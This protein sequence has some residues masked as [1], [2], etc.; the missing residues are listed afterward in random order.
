M[1]WS[2]LGHFLVRSFKAGFASGKLTQTQRQG[3]IVLVPKSGKPKEK[4][5][6]WRPISLLNTTQKI[7]S[8]AMANRLRKVMNKLISPSQKGFMKGRFIGECIRT[9][10]DLLWDAKHSAVSKRGLI[11]FADYRRA[12]DSLSHDFMYE[13]L[14]LFNFGPNFIRWIRVMLN[15]AIS[16][17]SQNK[18]TSEFFPIQRGCRQGDCCSPL[19]F[20]LCAEVLSIA[21]RNDVKVVGY[22]INQLEVKI[23][24]FA[25]DCTF[26]LDGTKESLDNCLRVVNF[27]SEAS[28][29]VL[30]TDKTQ[31][32]WVGETPA[33]AYV[34]YADFGVIQGNFK[35]LGII[36]TKDLID[37]NVVNFD[38]KAIDIRNLLKGWLRRKLTVYGKRVVLKT[39]ALA[40]LTNILM[41]LPCPPEEKISNLQKSFFQFLWNNGPDKIK[42]SHM[43]LDFGIPCLRTYNDSLKLSWI[44]RYVCSENAW[45]DLIEDQ[46]PKAALFFTCGDKSLSRSI[47][48]RINPF[49]EEVF[50]TWDSF[51]KCFEVDSENVRLQ[52]LFLS[53]Y[54]KRNREVLWNK[55]LYEA[56][57]TSVG[58]L[59]TLQGNVMTVEE[60][61]RAYGIQIQLLEH[62]GMVRSIRSTC[63]G[64][65]PLRVVGPILQPALSVVLGN[66]SGCGLFYK[67]LL[68]LRRGES[69]SV[70]RS[71]I[72]WNANLQIETDWKV[73]YKRHLSCTKNT[74]LL[75]FQDRILHRILT[76]NVFVSKFT[77]TSPMCTFCYRERETLLHLFV[78]CEKVQSIWRCIK[79][80]IRDRTRC[81]VEL[82]KLEIILGIN[83]SSTHLDKYVAPIQRVILLGKYY[84][85]RTKAARGRLTISG[86]HHFFQFITN[87]EFCTR[88]LCSE[89]EKERVLLHI[90]LCCDNEDISG[91]QNINSNG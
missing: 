54:F 82:N 33:P 45:K 50:R 29:L 43:I 5:E 8:A 39:L 34:T 88:E 83:E 41:M 7:L 6:S 3:M 27:F 15:G 9:V 57:C 56:G 17:I 90:E 20:I 69:R 23:E 12:F 67:K 16:C 85:Y 37:M 63:S 26:F 44:K 24:Q 70:L 46:L 10:Y 47:V 62:M 91:S 30:N 31:L 58:D 65:M 35:Y 42:R 77:D 1:F 11:V 76:T 84:I 75:W 13:V 87:A 89:V 61:K 80:L 2:E 66:V 48:N 59:L 36:F 49:W 19:L 86:M 22:R 64:P 14:Q 28:G 60:L 21:I 38:A 53:S 51:K 25:D 72:K 79:N 74:A 55:S 18:S 71:Q 68:E 4:T 78:E 52:P 32:L 81:N 40:K 73:V